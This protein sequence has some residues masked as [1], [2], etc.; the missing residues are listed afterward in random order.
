MSFLEEFAR[1][2]KYRSIIGFKGIRILFLFFVIFL[3][4]KP[5][6]AL[7]WNDSEWINAECPSGII[8]T[9]IASDSNNLD[10]KIEQPKIQLS[11]FY[12]LVLFQILTIHFL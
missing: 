6:L 11:L 12:L 10:K 5:A 3:N 9:W 7:N 8:G 2:I 1:I 4:V